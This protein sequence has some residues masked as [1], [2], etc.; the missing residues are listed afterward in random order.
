MA[1]FNKETKNTYYFAGE[2]IKDT[3]GQSWICTQHVKVT[4]GNSIPMDKVSKYSKS[5]TTVEVP[6]LMMNKCTLDSISI[7]KTTDSCNYTTATTDFIRN[8][9]INE[10]NPRLEELEKSVSELQGIVLAKK[11]PIETFFGV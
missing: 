7:P 8:V 11:K 4:A 6:N 10:I 3:E 2:L 5:V 1:V 9:K